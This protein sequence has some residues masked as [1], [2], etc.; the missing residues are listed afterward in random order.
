LEAAL[1]DNRKLLRQLLL[2][3]IVAL[4]IFSG[5]DRSYASGKAT[6]FSHPTPLR[7]YFFYVCVHEY[8]KGDPLDKTD[9]SV[10]YIFDYLSYDFKTLNRVLIAAKKVAFSIRQRQQS[11]AEVAGGD[12]RRATVLATCLEESRSIDIPPP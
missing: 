2:V 9:V 5:L 6:N 11:G 4:R 10:G 8:Y 1:M 7:D 12:Y 3:L